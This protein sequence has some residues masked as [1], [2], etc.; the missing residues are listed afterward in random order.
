MLS[1]ERILSA[2]LTESTVSQMDHSACIKWITPA[3]LFVLEHLKHLA[4]VYF[5]TYTGAKS[6]GIMCPDSTSHAVRRLVQS[7]RHTA[8]TTLAERDYRTESKRSGDTSRRR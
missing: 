1:E 7:W 6:E 2:V 5:G 3:A 8:I 4:F